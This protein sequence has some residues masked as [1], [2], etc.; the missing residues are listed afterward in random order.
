MEL[1]NV[2]SKLSY[3]RLQSRVIHGSDRLVQQLDYRSLEHDVGEQQ[4][5]T[6]P[7][8]RQNQGGITAANNEKL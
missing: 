3:H 1:R 7:R 8:T 6:E 5:E 4:Y 2:L